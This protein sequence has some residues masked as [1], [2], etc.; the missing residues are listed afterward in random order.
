M[1]RSPKRPLEPDAP[2]FNV[3]NQYLANDLNGKE[4][5]IYVMEI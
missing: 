2:V 3:Q 1:I 4:L 5:L